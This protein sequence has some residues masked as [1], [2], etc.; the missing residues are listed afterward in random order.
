METGAVKAERFFS[1]FWFVGLIAVGVFG[2]ALATEQWAIGSCVVPVLSDQIQRADVVAS[3][4]VTAVGF[5]ENNV[6]FRPSIVYKGTVS[7]DPMTVWTGPIPLSGSFFTSVASSADYRAGAGTVHTLYLR[8]D[9]GRFVTDS[10]SGSHPG[11]ATDREIAALGSGQVIGGEAGP[12]M[13]LIDQ[14]VAVPV[15]I[16]LL[17][18][19]ALIIVVQ[20]LRSRGGPRMTPLSGAPA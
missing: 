7:A 12:L 19:L 20:W 16:Y 3:G 15:L 1:A 8:R 13:Q 2:T 17:L 11:S 4:V 5:G 18:G 14:L 10:C 6:T 9:P